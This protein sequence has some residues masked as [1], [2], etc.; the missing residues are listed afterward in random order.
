MKDLFDDESN[1]SADGDPFIEMLHLAVKEMLLLREFPQFLD[2]LSERL[3]LYLP[4][5]LREQTTGDPRAVR[6]L[7]HILARLLWNAV[8]WP[9][10][11]FRRQPLPEPARDAPCPCGSAET[12]ADCCANAPTHLLGIDQV[13]LLGPVLDTLPRSRYA[14][15]PFDNLNPE[16]VAYVANEWHKEGRDDDAL[17]LLQSLWDGTA[18]RDGRFV[19]VFD[20]L[21]DTYSD[22][23]LRER[24]LTE[25]LNDGNDELRFH[26]LLRQSTRLADREQWDA[27]WRAFDEARALR[28]DDPANS[29][30]EVLLLSHQGRDKE[31]AKQAAF[32]ARKLK[33][34]KDPANEELIALLLAIAANPAMAKMFLTGENIDPLDVLDSMLTTMGV[35]TAPPARAKKSAPRAKRTAA[36]SGLLQLRIEIDNVRPA[37]WRRVVVRDSLTFAQLHRVI[38]EAL[39]WDDSHMHEFVVGDEHIGMAGDGDFPDMPEVVPE[40]TL[41]LLDAIGK[42]RKFK[43]WYDF[44][45][46]WHHTI[47]VERRLPPDPSAPAAA[48]LAG[49]R[50]CPPEDCGGP[51]GYA[52]M[53]AA[54]ADPKHDEHDMYMEWIGADFDPERFDLKAAAKR[55]ARTAR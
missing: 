10:Q 52:D 26:A 50:A 53:L 2:W 43:Y 25:A 35:P 47:A 55:V 6:A 33:K 4:D 7:A 34:Q 5:A 32:W 16:E 54:L 51:W 15:L 21:M 30:T 45:D 41:A 42:K 3:P 27:A 11:D 49:E 39:G 12:Y 31:A 1:N 44:G 14:K 17:A 40:D 23:K 20:G 9:D 37:V 24:T 22:E 8:P 18:R 46:D 19:A 28:P 29:H 48:L 38:Q 36:D 13:S